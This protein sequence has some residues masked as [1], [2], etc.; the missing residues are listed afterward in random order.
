MADSAV[1]DGMPA[2]KRK[3]GGMLESSTGPAHGQ[4]RVTILTIGAKAD[5]NMRRMLCRDEGLQMASFAGDR[6]IDIFAAGMAHLAIKR[7][8]DADQRESRL[9]VHLAHPRIV[10]PACGSMASITTIAELVGVDVLMAGDT[11][12][13]SFSEL[14]RRMAASAGNGLML[15]LQR[16]SRLRV[17]ERDLRKVDLPG[18][19]RVALLTVQR[20]VCPVWILACLS[21]G[22]TGRKNG[23]QHQ[24]Q[25]SNKSHFERVH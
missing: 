14:Q 15:P 9:L 21:H 23:L 1:G 3:V 4:D 2:L 17:I 16:K 6:Q 13:G 24:H 18:F 7:G 10:R 22:I 8:V 19:D 20:E 5:I 11:F 12:G 25:N